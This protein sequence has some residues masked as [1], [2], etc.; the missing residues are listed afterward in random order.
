MPRSIIIRPKRKRYK[1]SRKLQI[2]Q[3]VCHDADVSP[4]TAARARQNFDISSLPE[5]AMNEIN[6]MQT[7]QRLNEVVETAVPGF[8]AQVS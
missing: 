6:R 4:K 3:G 7:R 2:H 5:D 1:T 8:I